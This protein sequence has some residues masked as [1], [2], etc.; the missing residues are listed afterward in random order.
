MCLCTHCEN[1]GDTCINLL[2]WDCTCTTWLLGC[3]CLSQFSNLS[4]YI[5][6]T[7]IQSQH[8]SNHLFSAHVFGEKL[9]NNIHLFIVICSVEPSHN[10]TAYITLSWNPDFIPI[11]SSNWTDVSFKLTFHCLLSHQLFI[12]LV[13][14]INLSSSSTIFLNDL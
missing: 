6:I 11:V 9:C 14:N 2:H 4:T 10:T 8:L 1:K 12:T 13:K 5:T 3:L 7:I